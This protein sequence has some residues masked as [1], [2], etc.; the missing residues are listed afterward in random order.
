MKT[1]YAVGFYFASGDRVLAIR[2]NRPKWQCGKLNAPGG[3]VEPGES[4]EEA[5]VRE[6]YEETGIYV[7][8]ERWTY[9]CTLQGSAFEVRFFFA[10]VRE[11]DNRAR[12]TTD[13]E[14][15]WVSKA[16]LL[17]EGVPNLRWL[18]PMTHS[19]FMGDWP[20]TVER[21]GGRRED[22]R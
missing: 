4:F 15:C 3:H 22:D 16:E 6:F 2:K 9:F 10:E 5:M 11:S 7:A 12:T 14:V 21:A 18:L 13:E 19:E 20:F 17:T 1:N 8:S